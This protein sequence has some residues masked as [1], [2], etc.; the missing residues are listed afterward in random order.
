MGPAI[1]PFIAEAMGEQGRGLQFL[2]NASYALRRILGSDEAVR[3]LLAEHA[4]INEKKAQRL[5]ALRD[6]LP[7]D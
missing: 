7:K 4:E 1:A 5:R 2:Q 3:K 6:S